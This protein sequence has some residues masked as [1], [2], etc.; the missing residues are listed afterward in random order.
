MRLSFA[1]GGVGMDA[2][3]FRRR[4]A[5]AITASFVLA[6]VAYVVFVLG[7]VPALADAHTAADAARAGLTT[8]A[9]EGGLSTTETS[10]QVIIG[11]IINAA[12]SLLGVI[13]VIMMIYGGFLWMTDT[14]DA[15][16]VKKAK[17]IIRNAIIGI[18][19]IALAFAITN[20]VLSTIATSTAATTP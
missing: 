19:I 13:F 7:S 20:F 16:Q 8:T 9:S 3:P 10:I 2:H 1:S 4:V 11:R 15:A 5:H 18:V 17:D 6:V 12:L 14:G